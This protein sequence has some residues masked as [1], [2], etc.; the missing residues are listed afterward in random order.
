MSTAFRR[1]EEPL[2]NGL[3]Q[4]HSDVQLREASHRHAPNGSYKTLQLVAQVTSHA[5]R[6]F[7]AGRMGTFPCRSKKKWPSRKYV[8]T[9]MCCGGPRL[10]P[11]RGE[12]GGSGEGGGAR[13]RTSNRRQSSVEQSIR[14]RKSDAVGQ[15]K[16]IFWRKRSG[17]STLGLGAIGARAVR[18]TTGR[19]R[20]QLPI[21]QQRGL[22]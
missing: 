17:D 14:H 20:P 10:H 16:I 22:V 19:R 11:S 4:S 12:L 9:R 6:A 7:R 18:T 5:Q 1:G 13:P 8:C 21:E 2:Q 15:V 3:Q